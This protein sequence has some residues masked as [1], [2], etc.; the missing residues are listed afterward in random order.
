[1]GATGSQRVSIL[2]PYDQLAAMGH[3]ASLCHRRQ[4]LTDGDK[5]MTQTLQTLAGHGWR[6][7]SSKPAQNIHIRK[8]GAG[9]SF[10]LIDE[11][12][13]F[14]ATA[15]KFAVEKIILVAAQ[16]GKTG[17]YPLPLIKRAWELGLIN[18]HTPESC[19][20]SSFSHCSS[21]PQPVSAP[22]VPCHEKSK[23]RQRQPM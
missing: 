19:G 2:W 12:K 17:E 3:H 18:S 15:H 14:Q 4:H 8:P 7:H 20:L 11:Q 5:D 13:E 23:A 22:G 21:C 16:Y 1:M 6:S 9:F 10:E